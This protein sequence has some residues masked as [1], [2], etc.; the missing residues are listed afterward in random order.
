MNQVPIISVFKR[1]KSIVRLALPIFLELI[2]SVAMG[3]INQFMLAG[4]PVASNAVGQSNQINSIFLVSFSVF[5]TSSLI[6][7]TQLRGEKHEEALKTV[8]PL[9]FW[10]NFV[11]G[12]LVSAFVIGMAVPFF[13]LMQV[14]PKVLPYATLYQ[15]VSGASILFLALNQVFSAFLRANKRM[16]EP[17]IIAIASNVINA[18]GVAITLWAIPKDMITVESQVIGVGISTLLSRFIAFLLSFVFFRWRVGESL[19]VRK[20][21]PFPKKLASRL[22][23][24]GLPTAGETLSYNFSQ[25]VLMIIVNLSVSVLMQNLR[26]Y[27]MTFT[28]IIYLFANGTGMAMQVVEGGLI[29]EKKKEEAERLVKDIGTMARTV[30]FVVSI[31]IAG[32]SYF[33]FQ[34]L[35]SPAQQDP[36][37]NKEGLTLSAIGLVS[38]Y[39]MLIDVVLDQG[40]ATNLVYVKGLET[41]GDIT[42]PVSVSII[43]SW[44]LTVGV[45]A[46]LCLVF[47]MGIYGAF[48][49]ACLDECVR[50]VIFSIRWARGGWKKKALTKG[51]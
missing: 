1:N 38:V 16:T 39:C 4:I 25:L 22:L 37:I 51:I 28:S 5:S 2:L 50:G 49:G 23:K 36:D 47:N 8:Y 41:A 6:I 13:N 24:I 26:S 9:A 14:N 15:Y 33:V 30:S 21:F 48:I 12:I 46:L 35:M 45:S 10:V 19:S 3:Y 27:L 20:L 40:R 44:A 17:M 7:I 43:T 32:I 11:L 42:F 29:G 18:I 31:L 34:A